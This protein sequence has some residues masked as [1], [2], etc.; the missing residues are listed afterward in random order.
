MKIISLIPARKGSKGIPNKNLISLCG[1]PLISYAIQASKKSKVDETWVSSDSEEILKVSENLGAKTIKRPLKFSNDNASSESALIHFAENVNFDI[2]VFI[3]CTS[4]LVKAKDI[5]QGLKKIQKFDSIV[6]V[7]ETHQMF[8]DDNGPLYDINN[9]E[10]RQDSN[11]KYIE[12][13]SFFITSKKNL[14]KYKNRLSGNIG[15]VEI[16]KYRSFDI[17]CYDDIKIVEAI[18]KSKNQIDE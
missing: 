9:R 12:T 18:M 15:F 13:G 2:L 14:L 11:R 3:Q 8:W 6:S 10:R 4:P 16:P 1:K 7:S 5:N 17:D